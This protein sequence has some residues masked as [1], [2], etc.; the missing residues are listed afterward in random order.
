[1]LQKRAFFKASIAESL[2]TSSHFP[3]IRFFAGLV[4]FAG[5]VWTL[6]GVTPFLGSTFGF[7]HRFP[8]FNGVSFVSVPPSGGAATA[9]G[10]ALA[11]TALFAGRRVFSASCSF[12]LA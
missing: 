12:S 10:C 9:L 6:L 11:L 2:F 7:E 1:M 4:G 8:S 5:E 3:R